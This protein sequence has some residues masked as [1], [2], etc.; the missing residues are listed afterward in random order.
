MNGEG[1]GNV[2]WK[3]KHIQRHC[4]TDNI[5]YVGNCKRVT[6][7]GPPSFIFIIDFLN[8]FIE[9]YLIHKKSYIFNVCNL[10]SLEIC[11]HL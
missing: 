11:L 6:K 9:V 1:E 8:R 2:R 3:K 5:I 7:L 4:S 10:M